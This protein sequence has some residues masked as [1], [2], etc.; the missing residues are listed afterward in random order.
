MGDV[1]RTTRECGG[2]HHSW[3]GLE[4]GDGTGAEA[5]ALVRQRR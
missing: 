4:Q 3:R 2:Q 1:G 5:S